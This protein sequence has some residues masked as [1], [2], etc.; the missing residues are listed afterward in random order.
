MV[1]WR[2]CIACFPPLEWALALARRPK[3]TNPA[4]FRMRTSHLF[5]VSMTTAA[6]DW[7]SASGVWVGSAARH[8]LARA[9]LPSPLRVFG[10]GSLVWRPSPALEGCG[11]EVCRADGYRRAFCQRS[12]DHRGTPE[13]PGLVASIVPAPDASCYGLAYTIPDERVDSVLD[14]LDFREKGGYSADVITIHTTAGESQQ[15][16]A[17]Y[18]S[19]ENPMYLDASLE[20]AAQIIKTAVGPSGANDQYLYNLADWLRASEI[21]DEHVFGLESR[22][23]A[24]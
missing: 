20:E 22:V 17:Y 13:A 15:A 2:V 1:W 14:E 23:R 9:D 24:L 12:A 7:D 11:T 5:R 6:R 3:P 8:A 16:L 18:A 21:E 10:Y 4:K 19:N